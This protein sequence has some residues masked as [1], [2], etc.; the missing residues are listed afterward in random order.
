MKLVVKKYETIFLLDPRLEEEKTVEVVA[1]FKELIEK[2]EQSELESFDEW[3]KKRMAYEVDKQKDAYY[4]YATFSAQPEFPKEL[5][6]IYKITEG[7]M[8]YLVV[9]IEK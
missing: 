7:V 3:G 2:S 1:K 5:E 4:V 8:K 6:R 9:K